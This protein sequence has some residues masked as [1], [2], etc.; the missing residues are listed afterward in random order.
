MKEV[1]IESNIESYSE[2]K[3]LYDWRFNANHFVLATNPLRL[4]TSNGKV[5]APV[6]ISCADHV[7]PSIRKSW[8]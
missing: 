3:L 5:A 6:G 8:H 7:T 1:N 4:T 2:S